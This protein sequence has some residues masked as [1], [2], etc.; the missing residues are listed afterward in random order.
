MSVPGVPSLDA[1]VVVVGAG[2]AGSAVAARL[3]HAGIDVLLVDRAHFP[4]D[5]VCGDFLSPATLH[6][7]DALGIDRSRRDGARHW[8]DVSTALV[9]AGG[10]PL[11]AQHF[12]PLGGKASH[13]SVVPR[14]ELDALLLDRARS[15]GARFIPGAHVRAFERATGRVDVHVQRGPARRRLRAK[16]LIGA[17]GSRSVVAHTLRGAHPK[18][19]LVIAMRAYYEG[20]TGPRDRCDLVFSQAAFPG[21]CWVFPTGEHTANVGI[22]MVAETLPPNESTRWP[23]RAGRPRRR[24]RRLRPA[25]SRTAGSR[26]TRNAFTAS[27]TATWPSRERS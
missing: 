2:P 9:V 22:G 12:P 16:L 24:S 7:L 14:Y 27:W 25:I 13:G 21:Y 8:N 23:A 5:K 4:R 3:A 17:D 11:V 6:E 26:R 20:T 1:D 19:D 10:E 15:A 18:A